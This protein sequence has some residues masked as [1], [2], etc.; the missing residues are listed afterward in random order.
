MGIAES[1]DTLDVLRNLIEQGVET[2]V[3]KAV[4]EELHLLWEQAT[5]VQGKRQTSTAVTG[6]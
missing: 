2:R 1:A 6:S 3:Q 4:S 5:G